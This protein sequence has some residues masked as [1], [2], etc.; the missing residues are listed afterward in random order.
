MATIPQLCS[1]TDT[2]TKHKHLN[3]K[4]TCKQQIY[5]TCS[6]SNLISAPKFNI[7]PWACFS[8]CLINCYHETREASVQ[9]VTRSNLSWRSGKQVDDCIH[10]PLCLVGHCRF[11]QQGNQINLASLKGLNLGH[12]KTNACLFGITKEKGLEHL[13]P[14]C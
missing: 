1:S 5:W 4:P 10:D 11:F 14:C 13:L 6:D 7:D 2:D 8:A 3:E 12:L 9:P